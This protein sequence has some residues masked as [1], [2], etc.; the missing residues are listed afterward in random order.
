MTDWRASDPQAAF[1]RRP[2]C[3]AYSIAIYDRV[4]VSVWE[5]DRLRTKAVHWAV[6]IQRDG[7]YEFI[8]VLGDADSISWSWES[9]IAE[10][11]RRGLVKVGSALKLG[12]ELDDTGVDHRCSKMFRAGESFVKDVRARL[13]DALRRRGAFQLFT[14]GTA[15][16]ESLLDRIEFQLGREIGIDLPAEASVLN[17][18]GLR[19]TTGSVA[20]RRRTRAR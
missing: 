17:I 18:D 11:R 6:G 12:Y 13:N 9:S 8:G 15:Y 2:L 10:L 16:V 1:L 7:A 14:E 19:S 5:D 4:L 3:R 20:L